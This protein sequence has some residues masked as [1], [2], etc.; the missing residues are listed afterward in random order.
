MRQLLVLRTR[1]YPIFDLL[2]WQ[3]V[4]ALPL[5]SRDPNHADRLP[6]SLEVTSTFAAPT[7]RRLLPP[8]AILH[9]R[10]RRTHPRAT[11]GSFASTYCAL[12]VAPGVG[13][14]IS[15]SVLRHAGS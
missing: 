5:R 6:P 11:R 8:L 3:H 15:P 7:S 1:G 10:D 2:T 9:S 4:G 13:G 14:P 12:Y